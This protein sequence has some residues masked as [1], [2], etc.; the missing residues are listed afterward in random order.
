MKQLRQRAIRDLVA[1]RPIR[2]QQELAAALRERGFRTTQATISRD[3]AELG[4]VKAGREGTQAYALP[5]RLVEAETSGE[6]R[7]RALLR[8]LPVEVREAGLLLVVKT[9][10]GSAHAIAAALDRARWPEVAGSIAGDDT[11]FVA[12]VDRAALQRIR[13]RLASFAD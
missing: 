12:C 3:V 9:L 13:S 5:R 11:L 4:L 6:D 7:L 2:T 1:Q 8:D 10:P